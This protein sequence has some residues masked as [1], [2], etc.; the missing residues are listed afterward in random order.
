M[1]ISDWS[2]DVCSSD[3][4]EL[5]DLLDG[6]CFCASD[7]R[8]ADSWDTQHDRFLLD[9]QDMAT[10]LLLG[11]EAA[12]LERLRAI[13][14]YRTQWFAPEGAQFVA[15][16]GRETTAVRTAPGPAACPPTMRWP[17]PARLAHRTRQ[18]SSHS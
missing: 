12:L 9:A 13:L 8:E 16:L 11:D 3:L 1:R 6:A 4:A 5:V 17:R 10:R 14:A 2:S 7:D 18:P 15:V